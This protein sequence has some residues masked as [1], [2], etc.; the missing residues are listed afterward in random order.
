MLIIGQKDNQS[1]SI[2]KD[3]TIKIVDSQRGYTKLGIDA[4]KDLKISQDGNQAKDGQ[5][6]GGPFCP[7]VTKQK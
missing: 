4:P 1:F 6:R 3:I 5:P 2:G 7:D